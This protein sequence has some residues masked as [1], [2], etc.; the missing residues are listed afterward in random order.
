MKNLFY[1]LFLGLNI[2]VSGQVAIN[3]DGSLSDSGLEI[4]K[5]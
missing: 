1:L 2:T 3:S 5:E 4:M